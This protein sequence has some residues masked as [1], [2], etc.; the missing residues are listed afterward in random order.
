MMT[1]ELKVKVSLDTSELKNGI[2]QMKDALSDTSSGFGG[3]EKST[4]TATDSTVRMTAAMQG[5]GAVSMAQTGAIV[6]AM[7]KVNRST[8]LVRSNFRNVGDEIKGAFNFKN[9]DV[10]KNSI[11]GYLESMKIQL[12]EAGVSA[13]QLAKHLSPMLTEAFNKVKIGAAAVVGAITGA[14]VAFSHLSESTREY[15]QAINQINTSFIALGSNTELAAEAYQGFYRILGDVG[16]STEAANL[17]AQITTNEKDLVTWTNIATGALAMFPDSLP[18]ESLIEASNESIKNAKITG[19]LADALN[20]A[21]GSA[22]KVSKALEGSAE[23][24]ELFNKGIRE[25][26]TVEEAMNGVLAETNSQTQREVILRAALNGIYAESAGLYEEMNAEL[27]KQNEAQNRLNQAMAKLGSITQP[28]Q[29]AFT[30]FKATLANALAPAIKVVC[31][32][33]VTL[34]NWLTTAAAWVGAFLAVIFP[35]AAEK[36]SSAFSGV[37]S[38]IENATGGTG[39]LNAGLEEA[40]GT[41]QKLRK[42]LMGFDE[43]NVVS[44]DSGS[45]SGSD[46]SGGG[47]GAGNGIDVSGLTTGDSVFKKAQDQMEEMKEK[48]KAFLEEFKTEISI[49]AAALGL[50]GLANLLDHLGKALGLGEKF[51]TVMTNIKKLAATAITIVLQYSLVNEFM[52]KYIDGEGFKEY[53]KGLLVAAIGTGI[54]YAMWG[55]TGLVIGLAVTAAASIQAVIDNGGITNVESATV[56]L[57]GL[58]AAVGAIGVAWSKLGL[59]KLMGD[60]GAFLALLKEGAGLGPTLAATFPGIANALASAGTAISGFLGSIGAVFGATGT[61]AVVAGAAVIVAAITAIISVIVFLKENWDEVGNVIRNFFDQNIAPKLDNIKESF[62]KMGEALGPVGTAIKNV[63]TAIGEWFASIDWL[64]GIGKAFEV[65]GGII[66]GAVSGVIAGALN[67]LVGMFDGLVQGISGSVQILSGLIEAIIKLFS[68][69]LQGAKDACQKILDGIV[70]LF[71]GLYKL[72]VKPIEDFVQGVIDWFIKLWD[73]LVGHSIV[74][75]TID[76]IVKCFKEMPAEVFKWCKE[77]VEGVIKRFTE[78][79]NN[80]VT[81]A[82]TKLGELRTQVINSWNNIKSYFNTNIAPKFTLDYWKNK[83]DTMRSAIQTKLG[84]VRTQVMNSWNAI[85]SYFND[86]IAPKFTLTYWKN[87]LDTIRSAASTKMGEVKTAVQNGWNHIVSWFNNNVKSKFTT[88]YWSGKWGTIKDGAKSAFNGVIDIVEKAVNRIISKINTLSWKIPDWVPGVGGST[89]GFN[90]KQISIPRLATG[91]I[92][93]G[94]TLAN[95]GEN[96]REAVLPLDRNTQWMDRLADRIAARS[97]GPTKLVL[98]VG[99][100]ELGWATIN[101]I[102]QITKQTGELQLVL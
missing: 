97:Q 51:H 47:V 94:S 78:M 7:S 41:A 11:K 27:I 17:L 44:K 69:D 95:I 63:I 96:G 13:K 64:D 33:L 90:F 43:L 89:F 31:D 8:Q 75:D 68:G 50:L 100:R 91:G 35:G 74:P 25:G 20:W 2:K 98:K 102:N 71:T 37:S 87:K 82:Q 46:A 92:V 53:L 81:G 80:L 60:F 30:N 56:A 48:I 42:V 76:G 3:I 23:A 24:Q 65:L 29:T 1:E 66:F 49:I 39:G 59:G 85:K 45:S 18:I 5:L 61:G 58:A 57:T 79:W 40:E 86:N 21:Q 10:G 36:I 52:D 16:R 84:E 83:F 38:S 32:W 12:K 93:M 67:A 62:R 55:P 22:E 88:S 73:E 101:G 26:L 14:I 19:A 77:L 72:V 28:V 99:E 4:Q 9:F 6:V 70:D 54:L 15:R 34:I